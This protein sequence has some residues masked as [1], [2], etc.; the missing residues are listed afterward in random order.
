M[1]IFDD[2]YSE[3]EY[4]YINRVDKFA[5]ITKNGIWLKQFNINNGLSSVLYAMDIKDE[6]ELGDKC[7]KRTPKL[8]GKGYNYE[9]SQ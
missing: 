8:K 4:E 7:G 1:S 6:G 5:S 3:L 2:R 9:F